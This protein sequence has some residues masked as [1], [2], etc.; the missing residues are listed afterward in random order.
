[1]TSEVQRVITISRELG[2]GGAYLGQ[3]VARRLGY[4]YV[5]RQILAQAAEQLEVDVNYLADRDGRLQNY[6]DRLFESFSIGSPEG[7]YTPPPLTLISDEQLLHCKHRIIENLAA[8]GSCV[9]VGHGAFH[10]LKGLPNVLH[11]FIYA[12]M[13]FRLARVMHLYQVSSRDEAQRIIERS[14]RDR[15]DYI[16]G[17]SGRNWFDPRNFHLCIDSERIGLDEA[18]RIILSVA[19]PSGVVASPAGPPPSVEDTDPDER[20]QKD[21]D[22]G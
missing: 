22:P 3:R 8:R 10:L 14:D 12:S 5:D 15:K 19:G 20:E 13:N 17:I 7:P 21:A 1:M 11:V 2:S 18:E 9:I 16:R 4:A 6:W